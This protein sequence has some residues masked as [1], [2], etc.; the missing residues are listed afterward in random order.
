MDA[1]IASARLYYEAQEVV[2]IAVAIG[3]AVA[4]KIGNGQPWVAVVTA[5]A[6]LLFTFPPMR[7]LWIMRRSR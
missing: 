1:A 6:S 7:V 2:T 5:F 3:I 4:I